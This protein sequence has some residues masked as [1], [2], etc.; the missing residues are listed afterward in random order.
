MKGLESRSKNARDMYECLTQ[1]YAHIL[2]G[3]PNPFYKE[4]MDFSHPGI[5]DDDELAEK[6]RQVIVAEKWHCE[7]TR[8]QMNNLQVVPEIS[9]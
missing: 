2:R 1:H 3:A 6:L 7:S 9:H 8:S 4:W 5:S